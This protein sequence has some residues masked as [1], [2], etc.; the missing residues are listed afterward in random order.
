MNLKIIKV[1]LPLGGYGTEALVYDE[2]RK[3]QGF[4]PIDEHL[5]KAMDS[6]PKKFFEAQI[7]KD[8]VKVIYSRPV[9][10]PGW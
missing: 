2:T 8:E 1:Q 9:K 3:S 10:D 4:M 7:L 5:L 6:A